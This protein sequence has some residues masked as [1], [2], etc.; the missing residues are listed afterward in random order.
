MSLATTETRDRLLRSLAR[1]AALSFSTTMYCP[2]IGFL[3]ARSSPANAGSAA[4]DRV[5]TT[6]SASMEFL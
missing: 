4:H 2:W 1:L 6:A 5:A 3:A